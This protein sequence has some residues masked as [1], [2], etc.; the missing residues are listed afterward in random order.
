VI[1]FSPE[2][3]GGLPSGSQLVRRYQALT[4]ISS[5]VSL[6]LISG[7]LVALLSLTS[8]QWRSFFGFVGVMAPALT[9][10]QWWFIDPRLWKPM[11]AY[12]DQREQPDLSHEVRREAFAAVVHFPRY[13][14]FWGHLWYW[15]GAAVLAAWLKGFAGIT[16]YSALVIVTA[17]FT[18]GFVGMLFHAFATKALLTPLREGLAAEL[19]SGEERGDLVRR[20]SL[21]T[22]LILSVSSVTLVVVLFAIFLAQVRA[23]RSIEQFAVRYEAD[24][25]AKVAPDLEGSVAEIDVSEEAKPFEVSFLLV[26]PEAR[27]IVDGDSNALSPFELEAIRESIEIEPLAT[28]GASTPP[29]SSRGRPCGT[30]GS[31][32]PT[33]RPTSWPRARAA[34]GSPS[35]RCC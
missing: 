29:R 8:G 19:P 28:A 5:I 24:L 9:L 30:A 1:P 10:A 12:L 34:W 3:A 26:D 22:K 2:R 33:R 13:T 31:S 18:G 4:V 14:F 16:A 6:S 15:L 21:R 27:E 35:R 17:G 32:W 20:L 11:R 7:Y 23:S 25:A